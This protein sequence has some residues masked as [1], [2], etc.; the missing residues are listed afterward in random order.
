MN[1][2]TH[3]ESEI[4]IT[5]HKDVWTLV[6]SSSGSLFGKTSTDYLWLSEYFIL[7]EL[8]WEWRAQTHA[9]Y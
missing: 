7:A 4:C 6:N 9:G 5:S 1:L 8:L 3:K 2:P